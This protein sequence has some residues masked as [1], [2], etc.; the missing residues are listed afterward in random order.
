MQLRTYNMHEHAEHGPASHFIYKNRNI[1]SFTR[2]PQ[3]FN[4]S[5][6]GTFNFISMDTAFEE[7]F[8]I[9]LSDINP[10]LSFDALKKFLEES[11]YT[12]PIGLLQINRDDNGEPIFTDAGSIVPLPVEVMGK[13]ISAKN[14]NLEAVALNIF[15]HEKELDDI[16]ELS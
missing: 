5:E 2:V 15:S 4:E 16:I 12:I 7:F 6:D 8:G 13:N 11:H 10:I 1:I 14:N 9:K 3:I